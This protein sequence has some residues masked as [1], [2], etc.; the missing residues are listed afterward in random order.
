MF[1]KLKDSNDDRALQIWD[2]YLTNKDEAHFHKN[3]VHFLSTRNNGSNSNGSRRIDVST[4]LHSNT[5]KGQQ[6]QQQPNDILLQLQQKEQMILMEQQR[7]QQQRQGFMQHAG[8][9]PPQFG[10]VGMAGMMQHQQMHD[11]AGGNNAM[12]QSLLR[13]LHSSGTSMGMNA[14]NMNANMG[15]GMGMNAP[16]MNANMGIGMGVN[17]PNMN[18]N[19]GMGMGMGGVNPTPTHFSHSN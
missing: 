19:M 6:Q 13:S 1:K 9:P 5:Q 18:A 3:I 15:M 16:N 10:P 2:S 4:L 14:P 11:H 17:A 12:G 8:F 7:Q